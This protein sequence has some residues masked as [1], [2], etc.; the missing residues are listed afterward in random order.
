MAEMAS[1]YNSTH[2]FTVA[3]SPWVNG[4]AESVM[5]HAMEASRSLFSE[6]RFGRQDWPAIAGM[7]QTALNEA[8][9][10]LLGTRN[11]TT[12]FRAPVEVMTGTRNRN[13]GK[14]CETTLTRGK[15]NREERHHAS[16]GL[17]KY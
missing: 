8:P 3:Y 17:S 4:T 11:G 14:F 7:V 9:L 6:L 5:R 13:R 15:K 16:K 12:T 2:P 1:E 10:K